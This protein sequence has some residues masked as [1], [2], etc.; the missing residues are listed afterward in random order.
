MLNE[1]QLL[2]P[3]FSV[4]MGFWY[5]AFAGSIGRR[6]SDLICG[7]GSYGILNGLSRGERSNRPSYA[8]LNKN[9]KGC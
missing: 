7:K 6:P 3:Y 5:G 9:A 8:G 1:L 2:L 4:Q